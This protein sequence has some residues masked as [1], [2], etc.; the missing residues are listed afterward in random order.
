MGGS[1][2]GV[3]I[4]MYVLHTCLIT[5]VQYSGSSAK[6]LKQLNT[7]NEAGLRPCLR[8][9]ANASSSLAAIQLSTHQNP[10]CHLVSSHRRRLPTLDEEAI[11]ITNSDP[12]TADS[13]FVIVLAAGKLSV[14]LDF[15]PS[16]DNT[17]RPKLTEALGTPPPPPSSSLQ[18]KKQN[19]GCS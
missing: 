13:R 3:F 9:V 15:V 11:S 12:A 4:Y 6:C 16:S 10:S 18:Q 17:L 14:A 1:D 19:E 8:G 2:I 5:C 7:A